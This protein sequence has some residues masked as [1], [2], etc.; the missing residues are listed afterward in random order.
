[1]GLVW[2]LWVPLGGLFVCSSVWLFGF[3]ILLAGFLVIIDLGFAL[4]LMI[5]LLLLVLV[6]A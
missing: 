2:R 3:V 4:R 6:P 1:M 5:D